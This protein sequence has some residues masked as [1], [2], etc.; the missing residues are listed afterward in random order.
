MTINQMV[1]DNLVRKPRAGGDKTKTVET[2]SS[3]LQNN[4]GATWKTKRDQ[5]HSTLGEGS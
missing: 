3:A 1:S 5:S 2:V 4:F